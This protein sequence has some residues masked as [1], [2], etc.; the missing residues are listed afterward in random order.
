MVALIKQSGSDY[1][2]GVKG[3]RQFLLRDIK[4]IMSKTQNIDSAYTQIEVN[5]GR[6][7]LRTVK[8][9]SGVEPVR[10]FW[11]GL[12]QVVAVVRL[13]VSKG[14]TR[15]EWQYYIS[16][17]KTNAFLYAEG[18]RLHWMIE[19]ALPYVKD[20]TM[21]EDGSKIRSGFARRISQP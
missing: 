17:L 6:T 18:I 2:I 9:S 13:V 14:K 8:V 1:V 11:A 19:N 12:F 4:D 5:R 7:E 15:R 16:L 20:V 10:G 3:N 21:K